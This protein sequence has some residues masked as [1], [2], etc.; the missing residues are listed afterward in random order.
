MKDELKGEL[1]IFLAALFFSISVV[2]IKV[3][4]NT[5]SALFLALIRFTVGIILILSA[6]K[7]T[8][9]KFRTGKLKDWIGRG[10]FG[11]IA[12]IMLYWSIS[13]S[14]S[15]RASLLNKTY[16]FFVLVFGYAFF[17]QKATM[18][19]VSSLA[20][21]LVGVLF[22]FYDGSKY[23]MLSNF[24]GLLSGITA[25]FAIH[26]INRLSKQRVSPYMIYLPPCLIGLIPALFS[27]KEFVNIN[28]SNAVILLLAAG[29]IFIAQMFL[30]YGHRF[31][32]PARG[33]LLI[34]LGVPITIILSYFIVNEQF[35]TRFYIGTL[36]ILAGL[37][38]KDKKII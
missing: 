4:S 18:K 12:M 6:M 30:G 21:C 29:T 11:S 7:I 33:S 5:F 22:V 34:F 19:Q 1:S 9:T 10:I 17:S 28:P 37:F 24:I 2:L 36:A 35:T 25:G 20:L 31:V 14:S 13:L 8:K 32:T 3:L 27:Y 23:S 15:A 38:I 26:Y 16:P